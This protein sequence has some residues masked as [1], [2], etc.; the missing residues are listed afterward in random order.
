MR[1]VPINPVKSFVK[2]ILA[3]TRFACSSGGRVLRLLQV[4][5]RLRIELFLCALFAF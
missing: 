2:Q 3:R 5:Q 4:T 1:D